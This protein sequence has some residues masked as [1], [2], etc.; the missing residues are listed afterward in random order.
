MKKMR[1]VYEYDPQE[2]LPDGLPYRGRMARKEY[3]ALNGHYAYQPKKPTKAERAAYRRLRHRRAAQAAKRP[4]PRPRYDDVA[5]NAL[6][7]LVL[8]VGKCAWCGSTK[9]LTVDHIKPLNA[10]GTSVRA[11]LQCL[12]R[13]CNTAK[14]DQVGIFSCPT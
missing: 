11:N 10:G 2:E 4:E 13:A 3:N 14:G 5:W 7:A 9:R 12:C 8:E 6:R 1:R